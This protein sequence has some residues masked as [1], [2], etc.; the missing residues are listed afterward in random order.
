MHAACTRD[1]TQQRL[2]NSESQAIIASL[3]WTAT[4]IVANAAFLVLKS[5]AKQGLA[6]VAAIFS[7]WQPAYFL[8][9]SIERIVFVTTMVAGDV[10]EGIA[11][12]CGFSVDQFG[13]INAT[14]LL[15][16]VALLLSSWS[17]ICCDC[18]P[19][20]T[21]AM[22]RG[23]YF[24][25]AG[26]FVL[27]MICSYVW[28][29]DTKAGQSYVAIGP[30]RFLLA[31]QITSCIT[32]Q[33]VVLLHLLYVSCRSSRGRGWA[34]ASLRFELVK[35]DSMGMMLESSMVP[36][37]PSSSSSAL[38]N[39]QAQVR[40][41][42]FSRLRH[43]LLRF[44]RQRLQASQVF[45]IP[46]VEGNSNLSTR[47]TAPELQL[48]RPLFRIKFPGIIVHF[49]DFHASLYFIVLFM[50]VMAS[51]ACNELEHTGTATVV[52]NILIISGLL[53]FLSCKRYNIDSVA[54]KHVSTSFRFV[55]ICLL[56]L[57]G[58]ALS[59]RRTY[60]GQHSPQ[61][62]VAL[63]IIFVTFSLCLL[64]DC[65]PNLPAAVQ[66][67]ISVHQSILLILMASI[68]AHVAGGV[69]YRHGAFHIQRWI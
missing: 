30:F 20:F 34:Y 18:D 13:Q 31:D 56:L 8:L 64:V 60:L 12:S 66:T 63:I 16:P 2:S 44:Q 57:F 15:M 39:M 21:P 50:L 37:M 61:H 65:S 25:S 22:R 38:D 52:F 45:A 7:K 46:C 36:Q 54:A 11:G 42:V 51:V 17:A 6:L 1:D 23:A 35:Q 9:V 69:V 58:I 55:C 28:G 26:C 47:L 32:S 49:A 3:M 53:G 5:R 33:V 10:K 67:A 59:V 62:L 40:T 43:R 4:A 48:A 41:N 24:T 14:R 27:D 19:D 29:V 68:E